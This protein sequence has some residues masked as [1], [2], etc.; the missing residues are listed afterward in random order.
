[1]AETISPDCYEALRRY[2]P[3]DP[4]ALL[5]VAG[6]YAFCCGPDY[7]VNQIVGMGL[8]DE[9]T[10]ADLDQ[11]EDFFRSRGLPCSVVL[12]PL[13]HASLRSMLGERGYSIAEFNTVL[14]RRIRPE[15]PFSPPPGVTIEGVTDDTVGPWMQ[16]I[17]KGFEQD[18]V[19]AESVFGGFATLPGALPFLARIEDKVVGGC[20]G[21]VIP[22]ARIAAFFGTATLPE[23]RGRGVQSA[24]IAKR[25]QEAALAG[26]CCGE[27]ESGQ[28]LAAQHGASRLPRGVHQAGH[29][30]YL[31]LE[32]TWISKPFG[33]VVSHFLT[34]RKTCSGDTIFASRLMES[35]SLLLRWSPRPPGFPSRPVLRTSLNCAN[36]RESSPRR[37]WRARN[38]WPFSN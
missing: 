12:S 19:V 3:S 14:I 7:P 18:I 11:L 34:P 4:I 35:C 5:K 29:D 36:G 22:E 6:G 28:R 37:T 17:A 33:V 10:E 31:D 2:G 26:C 21:R 25:L 27:H 9:V 15:E 13:A 20:G 24:L 38:G 16:A 23:Y 8:Y 30:T 1:M 32:R